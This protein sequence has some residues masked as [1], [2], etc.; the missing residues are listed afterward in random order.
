[1]PVAS[2]TSP[3]PSLRTL[4]LIAALAGVYFAT[5]IFGLSHT[6][7]NQS[8]TLIWPPTGI[9]LAALMLWGRR[10][11]PGVALGA[12]LVN[13]YTTPSVPV[14]L[15][16]AAG[17]SCEALLGA[18][19]AMRY[20]GGVRAFERPQTALRFMLFA[21]VAA[22]MTSASIGVTSLWLGGLA[23]WSDLDRIWLTWWLGDGVSATIVAPLLVIWFTSPRPGWT[24][25][26]WCEGLCLLSGLLL[27]GPFMFSGGISAPFDRI[28]RTLVVLPALLVAAYRFGPHGSIVATFVLSAQAVWGL[29][30]G[31]GP[32]YVVDMNQSLLLL[33]S[34]TVTITVTNLVLAAAVADQ[35]RTAAVLRESETRLQVA[36]QAAQWGVFDYDYA[37]GRYYWTPEL[38]A[39]YGLSPGSFDGTW[40]GWA[41]RIHPEDRDAVQR[42]IA[43]A[44]ETGEVAHD[45]RALWS[46]NS[47]RWLFVRARLF[48][49]VR[50]RPL[51]LLGV[52][53]DVTVR[54]QAEESLRASEARFRTMADHAPVMIWE[55]GTDKRCAWFNRVWLEFTGRSMEQELGDG[56]AEGVHPDDLERC[57]RT[58]VTAFDARQAFEMDYR[59]RRHD[60]AWRWVLDRG[61]PQFG[62]NSEFV[63]YIGSCADITE[64]KLAEAEREAM[65]GELET[66]V[67]E[68]TAQLATTYR[69]LQA[70]VRERELLEA[71]IAL[72]IEREQY[73]LSAR[74]HEGLGQTLAGMSFDVSG[75]IAKVQA[76][77]PV[78][79][80]QAK[81]IQSRIQQCVEQ[82]RAIARELAPVELRNFGLA[83]ALEEIA[84][85]AEQSS[86]VRCTVHA[87]ESTPFSE[88]AAVAA[89]LYRVAQEAV[90]NSIRHAEPKRIDI[91]LA[92]H[93]HQ[94]V[95]RVRDDGVGLPTTAERTRGLGMQIMRYRMKLIGGSLDVRNDAHGGAVVTCTAP[96]GNAD[97]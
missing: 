50:G 43:R 23:R 38:E 51:R 64:R 53:V 1:M 85:G 19:L 27:A 28:L 82:V 46:D 65:R 14:A 80:P 35:R 83:V 79:V 73:L 6:Y 77:A 39:L 7:L 31:F 57:L 67:L 76:V 84:R 90:R 9:S 10:L 94:L 2:L 89:Q 45:F 63:G 75:L 93:D 18:W 15:G 91:E 97:T 47:V 34:Y 20:A 62:P 69:R 41:R 72:A 55:S 71:E 48:R 49:D 95:L 32:F 96:I 25:R 16:I 54:R 42:E 33:Q 13:Y 17:N 59:L 36:Q 8:V 66:R 58:Y 5:G 52:S 3:R 37:S 92:R 74:L 81:A 87:D 60:G 40:E 21:A 56:W 86:G 24:N 11:W 61:A 68:R 88:N 30:H 78:Q 70:E 26:Q 44:V 12:F 29:L 22:T 4:G